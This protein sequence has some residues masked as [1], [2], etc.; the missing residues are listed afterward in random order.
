MLAIRRD[1]KYGS[2]GICERVASEEE[3]DHAGE[4]FRTGK[5]ENDQGSAVEPR[6]IKEYKR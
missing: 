2:D 6:E 3:G 4:D 1:V 5:F